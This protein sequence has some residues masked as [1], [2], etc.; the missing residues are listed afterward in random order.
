MCSVWI[1]LFTVCVSV[2]HL[3]LH[4]LGLGSS[5]PWNTWSCRFLAVFYWNAGK[6]LP[7]PMLPSP[8][9]VIIAVPTPVSQRR[10]CRLCLLKTFELGL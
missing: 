9:G 2:E 5:A 7:R 1:F 6:A 10:L 4:C 3:N 8:F